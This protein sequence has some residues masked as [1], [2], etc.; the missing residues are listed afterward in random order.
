MSPWGLSLGSGD[1]VSDSV[2]KQLRAW[3]GPGPD[4]GP[5]IRQRM[6]QDK[7]KASPLPMKKVNRVAKGSN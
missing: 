3:C 6:E 5:G 2:D 7:Q 1:L 4:S